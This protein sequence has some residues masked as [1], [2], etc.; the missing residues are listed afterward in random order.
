MKIWKSCVSGGEDILILN[1][2]GENIMKKFLVTATPPTTNGDLHVG[3]LSGPYLGAD[4]FTRYQR[5]NGNQVL[6]TTSGDDHQS[7]VATTAARKGFSPLKL[8]QEKT[9]DI[10][11]TLNAAHIEIDYFT[12]SLQN[13]R[14]IEFVQEFFTDL[15]N[16]GVLIEK[17][18]PVYYCTQ[19]EEFLVESFLTGNCPYCD[20]KASGNLCEACGRV[21]SAIDLLDPKCTTCSSKPIIKEYTGLFLPVEKYRDALVAYYKSRNTWRP[22]LQALCDWITSHTITDYAVTYPLKWGIPVPIK[23]FENQVIN[24][25]FEMYPGHIE[26]IK[27]WA[28]KNK[29]KQTPNNFW[30][31][32]TTFVQFLG[33]DNSFFN[34]VLH[35]TLS[36]VSDGKYPTPEHIITNEFYLLD[37][38]KFSTSRNHAIWGK[39]ILTEVSPDVLR[40]Y[41][42]RTNP[43]NAQT[44]FSLKDFNKTITNELNSWISTLNHFILLIKEDF[45][46]KFIINVNDLDLKV[47]GLANWCKKSLEKYYDLEHFSLQQA[48]NIINLYCKYSKDYLEN[49]VIIYRRKSNKIYEH[50]LMSLGFLLTGLSNFVAP[51]MPQFSNTIKDS[52][53]INN[54]NDWNSINSIEVYKLTV[55]D[56]IKSFGIK[57]I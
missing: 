53:G 8:V 27:S 46:G 6:Y 32:D 22:H 45:E 20:E 48:S 37:N 23:G 30:D 16:K 31:K 25:W 51:I 42:C 33:Y 18:Q 3:H 52:L 10:L 9:K 54:H 21:N 55:R 56:S 2:V 35:V 19:C 12:N 28:D 24:V 50:R 40:Y 11:S 15:Y 57:N 5:L 47:R 26:T 41:L 43:E 44:N 17:T 7:Y 39:D 38:E 4:I 13:K 14:H 49:S 36:L 1:N 29:N 34:A